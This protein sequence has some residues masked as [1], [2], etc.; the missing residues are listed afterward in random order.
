MTEDEVLAASRKEMAGGCSSFGAESY[1]ALIGESTAWLAM[2][3][4]EGYLTLSAKLEAQQDAAKA[5]VAHL[6][7]LEVQLHAEQAARL[8]TPEPAPSRG[9]VI[10][11]SGDVTPLRCT[12]WIGRGDQGGPSPERIACVVHGEHPDATEPA[13]GEVIPACPQ[14]GVHTWN[15]TVVTV[16]G[17][18]GRQCVVCRYE[19]PAPVKETP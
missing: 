17:P 19:F 15:G 13:R 6:H 5:I 11:R 7:E 9:E 14:C 16:V 8:M 3:L 12:C 10:F 4:A 18:N 1:G 2:T